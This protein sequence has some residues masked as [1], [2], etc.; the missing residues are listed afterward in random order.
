MTILHKLSA[1]FHYF[2][3]NRTNNEI[4]DENFLILRMKF[5]FFIEKFF[6]CNL[7]EKSSKKKFLEFLIKYCFSSFFSINF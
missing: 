2:R 4:C 6:M 7:S 1:K 3:I 5:L